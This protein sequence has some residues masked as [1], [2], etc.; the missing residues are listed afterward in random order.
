[1]LAPGMAVTVCV[2]YLCNGC[3][4][5]TDKISFVTPDQVCF[6]IP[7][8]A[9]VPYANISY[10]QL[11]EFS[12]AVLDGRVHTAVWQLQNNGRKPC[13]YA[14]AFENEDS[15]FKFRTACGTLE[16]GSS[17]NIDIDFVASKAGVFADRFTVTVD[18]TQR[19]SVSVMA[20]IVAEQLAFLAPDAATEIVYIDLGCTYYNTA[21]T[22]TAVLFNDS[23]EQSPFVIVVEGQK[24][25]AS[26]AGGRIDDDSENPV[27]I[28]AEP[29]EGILQPFE[30]K[31][32]SFKFH[33][34]HA[35]DVTGFRM[36]VSLSLSLSLSRS[37]SLCRC[38]V[39]SLSPLSVLTF[40]ITYHRAVIMMFWSKR[41][42]LAH[43]GNAIWASAAQP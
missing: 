8:I 16:A 6:D 15:I 23:P 40:S 1:M 5:V 13:E 39:A 36:Q 42:L 37:L 29:S 41:V 38:L 18:G 17:V 27:C 12:P 24:V 30:K 28:S 2:E 21:R 7:I 35:I 31:I 33:P 22:L 32:V 34:T 43:Q 20:R 11:I 25:C 26:V 3:D 19:D 14:L 9:R 4:D 10:S